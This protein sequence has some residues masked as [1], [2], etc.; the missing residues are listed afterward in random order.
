MKFL[1]IKAHSFIDYATALALIIAPFLIVP[2]G[3]PLIAV[4]FSVVAGVGLIAYSVI[5]DYA[6]SIRRSI[7]FKVH[8]V[9]DFI[10]GIAFIAAPFVFGFE[11][12]T[13]AYYLIMGVAVILVVLVTQNND[14]QQPEEANAESE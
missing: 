4:W 5:T 11:G 10:A 9:I 2:I 13:Q 7:P 8:L 12:I 1:S 6:A 14:D 3:T